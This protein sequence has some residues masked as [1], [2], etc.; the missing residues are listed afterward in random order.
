MSIDQFFE[1]KPANVGVDNYHG[2][3]LSKPFRDG[4]S[5]RVTFTRLDNA[6]ISMDTM[7]APDP[8]KAIA[9]AKEAIDKLR[10]DSRRM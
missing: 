5:W 9:L 2:Y 6:A 4:E 7:P 3:R 1:K 10:G 8:E